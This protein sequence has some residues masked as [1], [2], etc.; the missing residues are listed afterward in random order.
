MDAVFFAAALPLDAPLFAEE[1]DFA[2]LPD[3]EAADLEAPVP[4]AEPLFGAPEEA[5]RLPDFAEDGFDPLL[6]DVLFL[7]ELFF[8]PEDFEPPEE[9][10]L[11][12]PLLPEEPEGLLPEPAG[13]FSLLSLMLC[14]F[15]SSSLIFNYPRN[16][17]GTDVF[18]FSIAFGFTFSPRPAHA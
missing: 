9:E 17:C 15:L 1:P 14:S 4:F 5:G 3:L 8:A 12:E 7:A 6:F 11:P 2:E 18:S 10:R 16:N 13:R